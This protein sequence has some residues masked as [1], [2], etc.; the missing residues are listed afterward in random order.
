MAD[1]FVK[2]YELHYQPK[3]VKIGEAVLDAQFGCLNFHAKRY[4]GS[5]AKLTV[6]MKNKWTLGWT[7]A[8]FSCKVPLLW[9]PHGGKGVYAL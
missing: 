5:G 6:A 3:K 1:G 2:R 7:K 8:R 9:S 4:K